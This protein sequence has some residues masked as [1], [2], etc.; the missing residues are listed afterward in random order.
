MVG[1]ITLPQT[2]VTT[3]EKARE[4]V[5]PGATAPKLWAGPAVPMP[6]P[7]S[8]V[9][10]IF[11]EVNAPMFRTEKFTVAGSPGSAAP[12]TGLQDSVTSDSP[13]LTGSV[14][15]DGSIPAIDITPVFS[16]SS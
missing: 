5:A 9:P 4:T 12:L 6:F 14:A 8:N 13:A 3:N 7:G 11:A 15:G 2:L 1:L 16:G 10:T